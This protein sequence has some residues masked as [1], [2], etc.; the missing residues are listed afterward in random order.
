MT[1]DTVW[2]QD[3]LEF[4]P[5]TNADLRRVL[6]AAI[7]S[8]DQNPMGWFLSRTALKYEFPY[9]IY[10][11]HET[12]LSRVKTAWNGLPANLGILLNGVKG[13]GKTI[14]AQVLANWVLSENIPVLV[15]H[16]PIPTLSE[17]LGHVSQPMLVI[18][19]EFEKTHDKDAQQM[20]LTAI[21]G[22][23]RNEFKRM[24]IFTTNAKAVDENF[25]DRP[26][27]VRYIYEFDRLADDLVESLLDDRLDPKLTSLRGQIM[28][29]LNTRKVLSMD[30]AKALIDEVNLF[31]EDPALFGTYFNVSEQDAKGFVI[32][33]LDSTFNP[34]R[35]LA[36]FFTPNRKPET[37][38]LRAGL[39]KSGREQFLSE[40]A[41]HGL[42][43]RDNFTQ[44]SFDLIEPTQNPSD[45]L[46]HL[47]IPLEDTW[48]KKF[49]KAHSMCYST[50]LK[51]DKRPD[52]WEIPAW[53]YSAQE[54]GK[55]EDDKENEAFREWAGNESIYGT[56]EDELVLIRITPNFEDRPMRFGH[57]NAF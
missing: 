30:T 32:E 35:T 27:R 7:Y 12:I 22:M 40:I 11:H 29:Y 6:P 8:Y 51:V 41:T 25:V 56:D 15:I 44:I 19:D 10:G 26:S 16:K 24:F 31:K 53:A 1:D 47:V 28:A 17:V 20:I 2:R 14:T 49:P 36:N 21:D 23:A 55:I 52:D 9:K 42:S 13:T 18:F 37:N 50:A 46:C 33:L 34:V 43:F 4:W 54:S 45:W 39:T 48:L 38:R 57:F 5:T 3:V